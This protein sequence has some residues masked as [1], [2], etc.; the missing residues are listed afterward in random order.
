MSFILKI[1]SLAIS[2]KVAKGGYQWSEN[3]LH[4]ESSGRTLDGVMHIKRIGIKRQADVTCIPMS[5]AEAQ[6]ILLAL[7]S[8][9]EFTA[10]VA[11]PVA[12]T[13]RA[14]FYCSA[15]NCDFLMH[16]RNVNWWQNL[17]FTL[18]EC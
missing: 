11:D 6:E 10:T 8:S 17:K 1:G 16:C 15:R 5:E 4:A 3:D 13:Y 7:R 9:A 14:S 12:G 2:D 18:I